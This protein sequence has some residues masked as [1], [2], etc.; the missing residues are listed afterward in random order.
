MNNIY[1][2]KQFM[3]FDALRG[4][5]DMV[6]ENIKAY[7]PRKELSE[8]KKSILNQLLI[9]MDKNT[10]ATVTY[11]DNG[12]YKTIKGMVSSLDSIYKTVTIITTKIHFDDIYEIEL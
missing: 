4:Y 5:Y 3:S 6:N 8:Y 9:R 2:A 11:Y 12:C 1:R 10:I 7:E